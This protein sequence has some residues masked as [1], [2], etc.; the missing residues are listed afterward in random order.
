MESYFTGIWNSLKFSAAGTGMDIA[1]SVSYR[2]SKKN[3][4]RLVYVNNR[5]Y[6]NVL[7]H[8]AKQTAMQLTEQTVNSLF[9]KYRRY[10]EKQLRETVL[11][12]QADNYKVLIE[13]GQKVDE[14]L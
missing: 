5:G 9:P 6:K 3:T 11:K 10:L 12:Q 14:G 1:G 8:V 2:Y 7:I 4:G 13:A